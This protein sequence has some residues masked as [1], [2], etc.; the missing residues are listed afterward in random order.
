[1][2]DTRSEST[3]AC[4]AAP[5]ASAA[6]VDSTVGASV[7]TVVVAAT[8]EKNKAKL[9]DLFTEKEAQIRDRIR[10]IVASSDPKALGEPGLETLRRQ[11]AYQL[12][13][14]LGKDLIKEILIPKCTPHR[15]E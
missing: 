1:M 9:T 6:A 7:A 14:D 5:L 4:D 8:P 10:T 3:G 12:E 15:A 13:Q 11:I 2:R